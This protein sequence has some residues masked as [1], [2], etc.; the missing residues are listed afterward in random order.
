MYI[1]NRIIT[2]DATATKFQYLYTTHFKAHESILNNR[3]S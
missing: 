1:Y 2:I 3:Q